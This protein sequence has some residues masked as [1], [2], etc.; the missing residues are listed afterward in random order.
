[1]EKQQATFPTVICSDPDEQLFKKLG[2]VAVPIVLVY[3]RE[4]RLRRKFTHDEQAYGSE[5]FTYAQHITP[6][7]EELLP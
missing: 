4:G 5:G 2:A 1:V 3:D 6:L 7:V